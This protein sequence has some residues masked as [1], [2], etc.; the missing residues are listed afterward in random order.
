MINFSLSVRCAPHQSLPCVKGGG[1][2]SKRRDEGLSQQVVRICISFWQ[3]RNI[4]LHNPSVS[5]ADSSL[6]TREPW[7]LPRQNNQLEN[8]NLFTPILSQKQKLDNRRMPCY[9]VIK[10]IWVLQGG[11][12]FPTGGKVRERSGAESVKLRYRQY[13]LDGRRTGGYAV[14][15]STP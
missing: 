2:P 6:Y 7:A 13:S 4:S 9:R 12:Q 11:V 5:Y 10:F 1:S 8:R 3:I 14:P 15:I